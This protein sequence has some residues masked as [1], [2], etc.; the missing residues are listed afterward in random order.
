MELI[1]ILYKIHTQL[2]INRNKKKIKYY[3]VSNEFIVGFSSIFK[4]EIWKLISP[5]CLQTAKKREKK[6]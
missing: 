5:P 4:T 3:L 2:K 1:N 6:I